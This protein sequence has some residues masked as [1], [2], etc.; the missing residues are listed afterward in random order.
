MRFAPHPRAPV[1]AA[2][3]SENRPA[4]S[5][6]TAV[7]HQEVARMLFDILYLAIGVAA[8]AVLTLYIFVCDRL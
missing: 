5:G 4:P 8:F 3:R 6:L 1:N 2:P 7:R